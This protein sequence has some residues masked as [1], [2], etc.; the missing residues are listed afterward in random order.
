MKTL[1]RNIVATTVLAIGTAGFAYGAISQSEVN[2]AINGLVSDGN[3]NAMVD[4]TVVTLTGY[5]GDATERNAI[6][7]HVRDL[8]GVTD[9]VNEITMSD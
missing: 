4:G 1:M 6:E 9:V 7:E 5:V 3:V 8:S 2:T